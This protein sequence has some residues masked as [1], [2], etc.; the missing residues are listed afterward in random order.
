[1]THLLRWLQAW[2]DDYR[3]ALFLGLW[4]LDVGT[5]LW[6]ALRTREVLCRRKAESAI[7]RLVKGLGALLACHLM[8]SADM[9]TAAAVAAAVPV[10]AIQ[11]WVIA[12]VYL[13]VLQNTGVLPKPEDGTPGRAAG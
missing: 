10:S 7:D 11:I 3:T 5:G 4:V 13:S 8:Q 1:M 2:V 6:H 12:P 9:S